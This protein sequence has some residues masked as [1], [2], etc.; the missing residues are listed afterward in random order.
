MPNEDGY[1]GAWVPDTGTDTITKIDPVTN[2]VVFTIPV[3][4]FGSE[5]S[6]GL[7]EGSLWVATVRDGESLLLR[8][9]STTGVEQARI[10]VP[11]GYGV[12]VA[13]GSVW[14]TGEVKNQLYRIDPAT[15]K[16]V[17]TISTGARPVFIT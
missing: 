7:G 5:G 14:V 3:E 6:V 9:D 17:A 15:N 2:S 8:Y 11:L 13:F 4:M 1:G 10:G 16:L 12:T